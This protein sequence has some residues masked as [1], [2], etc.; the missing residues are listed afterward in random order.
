MS[1][2]PA[3]SA[4]HGLARV[5]EEAPLRPDTQAVREVNNTPWQPEVLLEPDQEPGLTSPKPGS[6]QD[7][8]PPLDV[9]TLLFKVAQHMLLLNKRIIHPYHELHVLPPKQW[10]EHQAREQAARPLPPPGFHKVFAQCH[11]PKR[12]LERKWVPCAANSIYHV[13]SLLKQI[14]QN[15]HYKKNSLTKKNLVLMSFTAFASI[16]TRTEFFR[17]AE[18]AAG[19][20][21][22]A[23]LPFILAK[24]PR[25]SHSEKQF[26]YVKMGK[27]I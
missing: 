1:I 24:R 3:P 9:V 19:R 23:M 20:S 25:Y 27:L 7:L 15:I 10:C 8:S 2:S 12:H 22:S 11:C 17:R 6:V 21:L 5:G 16:S 14:P 18:P 4:L 13:W 26:A